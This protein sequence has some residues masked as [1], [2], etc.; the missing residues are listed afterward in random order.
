MTGFPLCG[1][2]QYVHMEPVTSEEEAWSLADKWCE[3]EGIE[4]AV[5]TSSSLPIRRTKIKPEYDAEIRVETIK[6]D[7]AGTITS[8][9]GPRVDESI[10]TGDIVN[11]RG[12]SI[13]DD[14][15]KGDI[16]TYKTHFTTSEQHAGRYKGVYHRIRDDDAFK[17]DLKRMLHLPPM[18]TKA[19]ARVS[20]RKCICR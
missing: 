1:R 16:V 3:E 4:G 17:Q 15:Q 2:L 19:L 6:R 9:T 13:P 12:S 18:S 10:Y 7:G 8:V 14:I 5:L 11:V 20:C